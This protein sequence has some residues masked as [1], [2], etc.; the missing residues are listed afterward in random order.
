MPLAR[1]ALARETRPVYLSGMRARTFAA[2]LRHDVTSPPA[3]AT[4]P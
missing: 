2:A 4:Q 3:A 1:P